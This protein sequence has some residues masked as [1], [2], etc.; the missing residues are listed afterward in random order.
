RRASAGV[1]VGFDAGH[2]VGRLSLAFTPDERFALLAND[3]RVAVLEIESGAVRELAVGGPICAGR[4]GAEFLIA[5]PSGLFLWDA[6]LG[7]RR[8]GFERGWKPHERPTMIA[9]GPGSGSCFAGGA[10]RRT[11]QIDLDGDEPDRDAGVFSAWAFDRSADGERCV[12]VRYGSSPGLPM[13]LELRLWERGKP[14]YPLESERWP[15]A[16]A[17]CLTP[18]GELLWSAR[19]RSDAESGTW[20]RVW[21]EGAPQRVN[22]RIYYALASL[23]RGLAVGLAREGLDLIELAA[24]RVLATYPPA[25]LRG[26]ADS[27]LTASPSGRWILALAGREAR[28]LELIR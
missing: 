13:P 16:T 11:S 28:L 17:A 24:G 3:A 9:L 23:G 27:S 12:L 26:F 15:S 18:D 19:G 1:D 10:N 21:P 8:Q 20:R 22:E 6:A 14:I 7:A 2:P 4:A 25:Q 5:E